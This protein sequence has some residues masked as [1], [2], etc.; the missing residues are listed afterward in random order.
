MASGCYNDLKAA[1]QHIN[2]VLTTL[3]ADDTASATATDHIPDSDDTNVPDTCQILARY[4]P[5]DKEQMLGERA[6]HSEQH[7]RSE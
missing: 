2:Q 3:A 5:A 6:A 7:L 4:L 1:L